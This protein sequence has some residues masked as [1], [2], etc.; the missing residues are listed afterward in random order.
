M[1]QRRV[2]RDGGGLGR[3][4]LRHRRQRRLG[5]GGE[6]GRQRRHILAVREAH[7]QQPVNGAGVGQGGPTVQPVAQLIGTG[8]DEGA[9][10]ALR[11][12]MAKHRLTEGRAVV[13]TPGLAQR[14]RDVAMRLRGEDPADP[15]GV[16]RLQRL[17]QSH[18]AAAGG[19]QARNGERGILACG[20][21]SR[22][23]RLR[24]CPGKQGRGRRKVAE[25]KAN[26]SHA[27]P[28]PRS[29]VRRNR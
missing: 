9:E 1:I 25:P 22:A 8:A 18:P 11:Q 17:R 3:G 21:W 28:L 14:R 13:H 16:A 23:A 2:A 29:G 12:D 27:A 4:L 6:A 7:H 20:E 26:P 10:E 15:R 5:G 24:R 19:G